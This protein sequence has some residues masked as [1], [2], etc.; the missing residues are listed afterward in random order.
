MP[1][2]ARCAVKLAFATWTMKGG[3]TDSGDGARLRRQMA[4]LAGLGLS[5][6]A[7]QFSDRR[8]RRRF[9]S[10]VRGVL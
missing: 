9:Y 6:A 3:G 1:G 8:A 4:L 10:V 5:A 2:H 7:F